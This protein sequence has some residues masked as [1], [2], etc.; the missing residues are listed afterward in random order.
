MPKTK[1]STLI[2]RHQT[3]DETSQREAAESAMTPRSEF[4]ISTPPLLKGHQYAI[5]VWK[6]LVK[7]Y[8]EVNGK[9]ITAF[10]RDI[11]AKYCL[12]SE[13]C[14]WLE[15]KRKEVDINADR[16]N[17]QISKMN[18]KGEQL[19]EYYKLL[20]Q[21]TALTSRVQGLDARLDGKRKLL[22]TFE[23]SLYLTPRS[24]AGVAPTL[25]D[26]PKEDPFGSEFD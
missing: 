20:E 19:K 21:Y 13:E 12:L 15:K 7:L 14:I 9:L 23:Q 25:K 24:R 6:R 1:P 26:K 16:L 10:D 4:D 3:K 5:N 22:L 2:T 18:P 8:G 11:L 17:S